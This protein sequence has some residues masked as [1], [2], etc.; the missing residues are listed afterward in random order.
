MLMIAGHKGLPEGP[1]IFRS[2]K[3]GI[4]L[5]KQYHIINTINKETFGLKMLL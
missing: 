2:K 3:A 4:M 5:I 1:Q